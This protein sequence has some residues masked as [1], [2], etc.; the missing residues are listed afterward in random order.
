MAST[1]TDSLPPKQLKRL[2]FVHS[3]ASYVYGYTTT[4]EQ[5]Y[6]RVRSAVPTSVVPTLSKLEERVASVAAPLVARAQDA[7]AKALYLA[8][9]QVG[10]A[11][12]P[13]LGREGL[14]RRAT[15]TSRAPVKALALS[16][17]HVNPTARNRSGR[18]SAP[19]RRSRSAAA[20]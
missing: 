18:T 4:A 20:R 15:L 3:S 9:D 2:G 10:I 13:L 8:D 17:V 11:H 6:R 7:G 14:A 5:L 12:R 16:R 1:T 19:L